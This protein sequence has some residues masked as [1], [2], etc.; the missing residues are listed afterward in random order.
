MNP[1]YKLHLPEDNNIFETTDD[2]LNVW[3]DPHYE[4]DL[5]EYERIK[6]EE[7]ILWGSLRDQE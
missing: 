4:E 3:G 5:E 1:D 6:S 7:Q 2:L